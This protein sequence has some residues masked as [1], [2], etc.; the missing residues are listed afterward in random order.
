MNKKSKFNQRYEKGDTPWELGWPDKNLINVIKEQQIQPGKALD[1]GCGTASNAIWLAQNK[2]EVTGADFSPLA[3]EKAKERIQ[4]Q[5]VNIQLLVKD[6]LSLDV[7]APDFEFIFDRGCFHG[8]DQEDYR[9]QF[10]QNV[11]SHLKKDGVWLSLLGNYDDEPRDEGPP[12]RSALEIVTAVEPFFKI[13]FLES[14]RFDSH[15]EKPAR[16]WVCFMRKR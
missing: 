12:M 6:F 8:F 11:W 15:R 5:G 10:A 13:L 3:I 1:I 4:H 14:G 16:C 7:I 2:F 9:K